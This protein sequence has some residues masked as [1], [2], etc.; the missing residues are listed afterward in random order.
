MKVRKTMAKISELEKV[1]LQEEAVLKNDVVAVQH[2]YDEHKQFEFVA[3]AL[4]LACRYGSLEMVQV[5]LAHGVTFQYDASPAMIKKYQCKVDI[6]A[7][8]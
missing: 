7:R 2:L 8:T 1:Q 5:L 6:V 4:G 3:R